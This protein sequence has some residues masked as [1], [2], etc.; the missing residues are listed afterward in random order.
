MKSKYKLQ[1]DANTVYAEIGMYFIKATKDQY[2]NEKLLELMQIQ[3]EFNQLVEGENKP[4]EDK[5]NE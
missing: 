1:Q 4:K 5:P 3:H 2:L